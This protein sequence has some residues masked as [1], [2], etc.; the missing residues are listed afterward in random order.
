MR[1]AMLGMMAVLASGA[2]GAQSGAVVRGKVI[3][4]R[5]WYVDGSGRCFFIAPGGDV[6][7]D[8]QVACKPSAGGFVVLGQKPGM[9]VNGRTYYKD[10]RGYCYYFTEAAERRYDY[11]LDC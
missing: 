10:D 6:V 9:Q 1:L 3:A 5:Q 7:Y 4:G 8:A 2:A 11:D